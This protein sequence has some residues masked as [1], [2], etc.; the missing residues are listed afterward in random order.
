MPH[1]QL[2]TLPRATLVRQ[3][4]AAVTDYELPPT[5]VRECGV[6]PRTGRRSCATPGPAAHPAT[7]TAATAR[8]LAEPLHG[9]LRE[10]QRRCTQRTDALGRSWTAPPVAAAA[11]QHGR[12][13]NERR[14]VAEAGGAGPCVPQPPPAIALASLRGPTHVAAHQLHISNARESTSAL[15]LSAARSCTCA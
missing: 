8:S 1:E 7:C 10:P 15:T 11:S 3:R 5:Q 6:A 9:L 2:Q 12:G 14:G 4:P 13:T